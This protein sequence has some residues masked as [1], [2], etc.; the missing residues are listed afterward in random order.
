MESSLNIW[1]K[2]HKVYSAIGFYLLT[3]LVVIIGNLLEPTSL[4]GP[5]LDMVF[6][7]IM[8]A[9]SIVLLAR[10]FF[11]VVKKDKA[12]IPPLIVHSIFWI[13]F[14]VLCCIT[15]AISKS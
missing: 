6:G 2:T 7:F 1:I 9:W 5:G 8:L 15:E 4:A 13:A 10:C 3:F 14:V 11:K 12:Y